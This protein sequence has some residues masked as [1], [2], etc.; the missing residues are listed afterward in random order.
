M[1]LE[2]PLE[3]VESAA[4]LAAAAGVPVILDP[5]PV[6]AE[7]LSDSLLSK[8]TYLKP[9]ETEAERLTGIHVHDEASARARC[10]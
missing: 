5:A 1:Q 10:Q 2:I 4:R 6:P 7:R 8:V 3:T 9:N